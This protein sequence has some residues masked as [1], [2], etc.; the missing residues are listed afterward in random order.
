[1][2]YKKR[3]ENKIKR[4][5]IEQE[6]PLITVSTSVISTEDMQDEKTTRFDRFREEIYDPLTL[7]AS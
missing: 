2:K 7:I 6:I 3:D 1:M 4:D 5:Y